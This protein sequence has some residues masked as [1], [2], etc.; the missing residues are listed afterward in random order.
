[1]CTT[2]V[3]YKHSNIFSPTAIGCTNRQYHPQTHT[4]GWA[5]VAVSGCSNKQRFGVYVECGLI[6]I[7]NLFSECESETRVRILYWTRS[8]ALT[9]PS[10][11]SQCAS[12]RC[13]PPWT[14]QARLWLGE[15]LLQ[16]KP[17]ESNA[18]LWSFVVHPPFL[19]TPFFRWE[20]ATFK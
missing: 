14:S 16:N 6:V 2:K 15:L 4:I 13:E 19:L 17:K 8:A 1:M 10:P 7:H 11:L 18:N 9:V 5:N 3:N 20:K 12:E